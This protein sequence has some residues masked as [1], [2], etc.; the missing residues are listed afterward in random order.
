MPGRERFIP[1]LIQRPFACDVSGDQYLVYQFRRGRPGFKLSTVNSAVVN[2]FYGEG[3]DSVM[4]VH[5]P[6][7]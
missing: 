7:G 4:D 1:Q 5:G 6:G 2:D 3:A